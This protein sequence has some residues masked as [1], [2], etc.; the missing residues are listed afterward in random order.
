MAY[1]GLGAGRSQRTPLA[2][3]LEVGQG[4]AGI[5]SSLVGTIDGLRRKSA[6]DMQ[7]SAAVESGCR[8]VLLGKSTQGAQ[9]SCVRSCHDAVCT[10]D[11]NRSSKLVGKLR[12][13]CELA[14]KTE[15][16]RSNGGTMIRS[17]TRKRTKWQEQTDPNGR[18]TFLG[19]SVG[20]SHAF[21]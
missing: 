10:K 1:L 2:L 15:L 7:S 12:R 16:R 8:S 5:Q 9:G 20:G 13:D 14:Q 6:S 3:G 17:L 18:C 19:P 4:A 11:R 21:C